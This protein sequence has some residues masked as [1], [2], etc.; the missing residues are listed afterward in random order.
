MSS[1]SP[2]AQKNGGRLVPR[3]ASGPFHPRRPVVRAY[4]LPIPLNSLSRQQYKHQRFSY[5]KEVSVSG[6][7][8]DVWFGVGHQDQGSGMGGATLKGMHTWSIG[9]RWDNS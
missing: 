6:G 2:S 1:I 4:I 9:K 7:V 5:I 8:M 3:R